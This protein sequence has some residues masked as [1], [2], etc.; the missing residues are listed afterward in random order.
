MCKCT[1]GLDDRRAERIDVRGSTRRD[2]RSV[3]ADC[4]ITP[5]APVGFHHPATCVARGDRPRLEDTGGRKRFCRPRECS[6]YPAALQRS[7]NEVG[8]LWAAWPGWIAEHKRVE[9]IEVRQARIEGE[10]LDADAI[11]CVSNLPDES[12]RRAR[13]RG[14]RDTSCRCT[15][16]SH[17]RPS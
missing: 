2:N 16:A 13:P 9:R 7:R 1:Y 10:R 11:E 12:V 17:E 8:P 5:G 6:G 15:L 4:L 3:P 14:E